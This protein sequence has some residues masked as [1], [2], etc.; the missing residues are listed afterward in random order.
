MR[1][2]FFL[3]SSLFSL[4]SFC[5]RNIT[6]INFR[7]KKRYALHHCDYPDEIPMQQTNT[8]V[9]H[10]WLVPHLNNRWISRWMSE[11]CINAWDVQWNY[12]NNKFMMFLDSNTKVAWEYSALNFSKTTRYI[13]F[14]WKPWGHWQFL[15]RPLSIDFY[16]LLLAWHLPVIQI[17]HSHFTTTNSWQNG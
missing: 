14:I 11:W 7:N 10:L 6:G 5:M 9:W 16:L 12:A 13:K 3:K 15:L 2:T 17:N 8:H 4:H 1:L